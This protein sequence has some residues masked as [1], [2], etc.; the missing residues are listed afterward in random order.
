MA[1]SSTGSR[2]GCVPTASRSASDTVSKPRLASNIM[3]PEL[4][5]KAWQQARR[6]AEKTFALH[7]EAVRVP[8]HSPY[9]LKQVLD[10]DFFP[11]SAFD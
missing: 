1:L 11:D 7:R 6:A 4:F 10:P 5:E 2:Q 3:P 8:E 9:S